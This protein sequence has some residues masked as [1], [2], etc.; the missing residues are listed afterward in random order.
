M[1]CSQPVLPP[2]PLVRPVS[3]RL[4]IPASP[5]RSLEWEED[6][7]FGPL[8]PGTVE[9]DV[10]WLAWLAQKE[11]Q[12]AAASEG[13]RLSI[14]SKQRE[15]ASQ[16]ETSRWAGMA[17]LGGARAC[18]QVPCQH[19]LVQ[20]NEVGIFV[21][22]HA[23]KPCTHL[24][25]ACG[26]CSADPCLPCSASMGEAPSCLGASQVSQEGAPCSTAISGVRPGQAAGG[27]KRGAKG[28]GKVR[29]AHA[30]CCEML[31]SL[32]RWSAGWHALNLPGAPCL[33]EPA[34]PPNTPP[35]RS[36]EQAQV[37]A[38]QQQLA[39]RDSAVQRLEQ[40]LA[41]FDADLPG[42]APSPV[43][44]DPGLKYQREQKDEELAQARRQT[45]E[46]REELKVGL[47]GQHLPTQHQRSLPSTWP[48]A[49]CRL[50]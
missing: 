27:A 7:T 16:G 1:H 30:T 49:A 45:V 2:G 43:Q 38:L 48:V 20:C 50:S 28:K 13:P 34:H 8:P 24:V 12:R 17:A 31:R 47:A 41:A 5:P 32:V 46:R 36:E 26:T 21:R 18:T 37:A 35:R 14:E 15:L 11:A 22:E 39:E 33:Q 6:E 19:L 44:V 40:A 4:C 3:R 9:Q 10:A 25:Q 29:A 23:C 42:S